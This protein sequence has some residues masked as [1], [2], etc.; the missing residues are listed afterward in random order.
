[1]CYYRTNTGKPWVGAWTYGLQGDR[2]SCH[3]PLTFS[4]H[5]G[6]GLFLLGKVS[7]RGKEMHTSTRPTQYPSSCEV[8]L[9]PKEA[10]FLSQR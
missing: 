1:M 5:K 6:L 9:G 10:A 4:M 8:L 7:A 2:V 3:L